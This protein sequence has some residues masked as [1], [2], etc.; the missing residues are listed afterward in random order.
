[1]SIFCPD[2]ALPLHT[3]ACLPLLGF[4]PGIFPMLRMERERWRFMLHMLH[5]THSP[6]CHF[7][8][9]PVDALLATRSNWQ[10]NLAAACLCLRGLPIAEQGEW[11]ASFLPRIEF[12]F[13]PPPHF[14]EKK[15]PLGDL[16]R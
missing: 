14:T 11:V 5:L 15:A 6:P 4:S 12:F 9:L 10:P 7:F 13:T 1:M 2:P 8:L 3:L 16:G